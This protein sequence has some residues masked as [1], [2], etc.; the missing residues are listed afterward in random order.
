MITYLIK[1]KVAA[2]ESCYTAKHGV[3]FI[4]SACHLLPRLILVPLLAGGLPLDQ[5]VDL[6]DRFPPINSVRVYATLE[7]SIHVKFAATARAVAQELEDAL[8]PAHELIEKPVVVNVDF[9]Y[10][11]VKVVFM[12]RAQVDE[13]LDGLIGVCGDFLT[14]AGFDGLD[15][16]VDEYS[17]VSDAIVNICRLVYA[18]ERLVED[19]EEVAEKLKGSGL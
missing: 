18:N 5:A 13:S 16:V 10:E 14:L 12:A 7:Q 8:Q 19:G 6:S 9:V 3:G 15:C 17:E 2:L 4:A 11:L 1:P